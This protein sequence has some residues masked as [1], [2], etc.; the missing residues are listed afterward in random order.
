MT[1][2]KTLAFLLPVDDTPAIQLSN[3]LWRKQIL[4]RGTIT[5]QGKKLAFDDK[6]FGEVQ[7]AFNKGAV[8]ADGMVPFVLANDSNDHT[9]D[10]K[11]F[12][13][14]IKG[15]EV[16]AR[17]MDAILDLTP[18]S[19]ELVGKTKGK[20]G[21]SVKVDQNRE[22]EYGNTHPLS[23]VHVL[24]TLDP[25]VR[26]LGAWEEVAA[27]SN[28]GKEVTTVDLTSETFELAQEENEPPPRDNE[29]D[30]GNEQDI[31]AAL[32]LALA[33]LANDTPGKEGIELATDTQ[34]AIELAVAPYKKA[35]E[36]LQRK[37]AKTEWDSEARDLSAA[38]VPPVM[39]EL[40]ATVLSDPASSTI[41]L[42]N[43]AKTDVAKILRGM[44]SASKGMIELAS[45]RGHSF[46]DSDDST[47][48]TDAILDK[49]EV[50][51]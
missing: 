1:D 46:T 13:G 18:D 24:G 15:L 39:I 31:D 36:A 32:A 29:T 20:L 50:D 33:S 47:D 14:V 22:T 30:D 48:A 41:E 5:Y 8:G 37:N 44:L 6:F 43:G 34:G 26:N 10:P 25:K 7:K 17:G 28:G 45:E 9:M 42:S 16:G 23:L 51:A 21:V 2:K 19:V 40:A 3:T 4:P 27:L 49:W 12:G 11:R 38:G 35:V